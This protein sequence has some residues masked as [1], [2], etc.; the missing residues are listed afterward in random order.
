MS[1]KNCPFKDENEAKR[2]FQHLFGKAGIFS[3]LVESGFGGSQ[4]VPDLFMGMGGYGILPI[5]FKRGTIVRS[6]DGTRDL[7]LDGVQPGQVRYHVEAAKYAQY[8]K[9]VTL[10]DPGPN[11]EFNMQS[12][13]CTHGEVIVDWRTGI[14]SLDWLWHMPV[15]AITPEIVRELLLKGT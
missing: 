14:T 12:F 10:I 13:I 3:F 6:T 15:A 1:K 2:Y 8:T 5:E 9:I 4:G 7:K 11:S